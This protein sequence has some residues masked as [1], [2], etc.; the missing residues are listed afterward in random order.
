MHFLTLKNKAGF[1]NVVVRPDIY[2]RYCKV[3]RGIACLLVTGVAER[4]EGV[5]NLL[6]F[7]FGALGVIRHPLSRSTRELPLC[8][9]HRRLPGNQDGSQQVSCQAKEDY[10][11]GAKDVRVSREGTIPMER[12]EHDKHGGSLCI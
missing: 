11:K 7:R 5:S 10:V 8:S 6:A 4:K 3:I 1:I 12:G 2:A 9:T